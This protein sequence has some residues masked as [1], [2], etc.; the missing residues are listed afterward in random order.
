MGKKILVYG[1]DILR[2]NSEYITKEDNISALATS[3]F[4]TLKI[5]EGIGLAAPQV[6]VLKRMFIINTESVVAHDSSFELIKRVVINPE[7]ITYSNNKVLFKE[8]C[9][10][11]P[12]ICERVE[13]PAEIVVKYFNEQMMPEKRT[14]SGLEA[15]IFQHELDHLKGILF[16]D[17]VSAIR[18]AFLASKLKR[19][20]RLSKKH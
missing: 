4:D 15:R 20:Q 2:N 14:I 6:G 19:L 11:V 8:A 13:R 17:R 12:G 10:S 5:E 16:I 18:R 9:L 1:S 7:I 3:L